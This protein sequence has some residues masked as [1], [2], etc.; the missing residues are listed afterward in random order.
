VS[1][2]SDFVPS[3]GCANSGGTRRRTVQLNAGTLS[4]PDSLFISVS[5]PSRPSSLLD[6]SSSHCFIDTHFVNKLDLSLYRIRPVKLRLFDGSLGS[7]IT[8][9]MDLRICHSTSDI[10]VVTFLVTQLD[11]PVAL[12]FEYT[13]FYRYNPLIDWYKSQI[14]SFQTPSQVS[15]PTLI[16]PRLPEL[17]PTDSEPIQPQSIPTGLPLP[18]LRPTNSVPPRPESPPSSPV[19]PEVPKVEQPK[20]SVSFIN[21]PAYAC[22]ARV[23]GSVSFQLSLSDPSLCERS[24]STTPA[25]PDMSG[26]PEEYHEYADVFSK[27]R[28]DTLPDHRP[29]NL[30]IDLEDSAEPSLGRMYQYFMVPR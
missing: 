8:H 20:P 5:F 28:A 11:P 29:Y 14:L 6:C 18:E 23:E 26:I 27:K 13:W 16:G 25:E 15:K 9:A 7:Q 30:K 4:E 1:S 10:F 2:P 21:A 22:A 24:S 12:V 17:R 3:G 19:T